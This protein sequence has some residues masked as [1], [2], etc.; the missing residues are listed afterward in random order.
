MQAVNFFCL[1]MYRKIFTKLAGGIF[2]NEARLT[3]G[4]LAGTKSLVFC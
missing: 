2:T 1:D 3:A 4:A